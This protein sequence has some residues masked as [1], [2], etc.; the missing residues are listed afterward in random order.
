MER[1]I[2]AVG[3]KNSAHGRESVLN[4]WG[5]VHKWCL[6]AGQIWNDPGRPAGAA[7]PPPSAADAD[8]GRT[9]WC[10]VWGHCMQQWAQYWPLKGRVGRTQGARMVYSRTFEDVIARY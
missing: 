4:H 6:L 8:S 3:R 5:D 1:S 9:L 2:L 7:S 10:T